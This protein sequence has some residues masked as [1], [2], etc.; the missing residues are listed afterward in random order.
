[1]AEITPT[2]MS[3]WE[4]VSPELSEEELARREQETESYSTGELLAY[5]ERL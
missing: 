2:D 3:E 4:P 1:M 5:L